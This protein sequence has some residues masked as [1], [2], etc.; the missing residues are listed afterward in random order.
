MLSGKNFY[1]IS[2]STKSKDMMSQYV[3][4]FGSITK[5]KSKSTGHTYGYA[6]NELYEEFMLAIRDGDEKVTKSIHNSKTFS[7]SVD[8]IISAKDAIFKYGLGTAAFLAVLTALQFIPVA[9]WLGDGALWLITTVT[10][11]GTLKDAYN[12]ATN[13]KD[14]YNSSLSAEEYYKDIKGI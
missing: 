9:N 8:D 5:V 7:N 10:G 14:Y 13:I 6:Y 4:Q 11:A 12:L 2:Y 3:S 1:S